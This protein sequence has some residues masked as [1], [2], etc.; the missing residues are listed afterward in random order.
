[1]A[2]AAGW[3]A[4]TGVPPAAETAAVAI[5]NASTDVGM[6]IIQVMV[7]PRRKGVTDGA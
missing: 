1:V 2:S 6:E 5:A 3:K 7:G 4:L